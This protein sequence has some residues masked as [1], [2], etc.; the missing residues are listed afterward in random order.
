MV[1]LVRN[2]EYIVR[3]IKYTLDSCAVVRTDGS[4]LKLRAGITLL[5]IWFLSTAVVPS[6]AFRNIG[7]LGPAI[8]VL[9]DCD[10]CSTFDDCLKHQSLESSFEQ[11]IPLR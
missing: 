7:T 4:Y 3:P 6:M 11:H 1:Q 2:F 5:A 9:H 8:V 10:I